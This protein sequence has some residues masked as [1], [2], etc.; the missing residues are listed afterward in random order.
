M[1]EKPYRLISPDEKHPWI[2]HGCWGEKSFD[3]ALL[4]GIGYLSFVENLEG[5]SALVL[6]DEG[7]QGH[8]EGVFAA[9]GR[10]PLPEPV[11]RTM[12]DD[13]EE[14]SDPESEAVYDAWEE[15]FSRIPPYLSPAAESDKRNLGGVWSWVYPKASPYERF[16]T[17]VSCAYR[18]FD[19]LMKVHGLPEN[20]IY[21]LE[22]WLFGY[23][24][25]IIAAYEAEYGPLSNEVIEA[26]T[27]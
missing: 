12:E 3:I 25:E 1:S 5:R 8:R 18:T 19:T 13:Y 14:G 9:F 17:H 26:A 22:R 11:D 15:Y 16:V 24:G 20:R 2:C 21:D 4:S 6:L 7:G 23:C 27:H 10:K